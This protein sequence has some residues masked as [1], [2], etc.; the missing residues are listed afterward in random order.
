MSAAHL[1]VQMAVQARIWN[2]Q[3]CLRAQTTCQSWCPGHTRVDSMSESV[4]LVLTSMGMHVPVCSQRVRTGTCPHAKVLGTL[5]WP[6]PSAHICDL[7]MAVG[8]IGIMSLQLTAT[9][10]RAAG[11]SGTAG[12]AAGV[13][14]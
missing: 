2:A 13:H 9:G 1:G 4:V 14:E 7:A 11:C 12:G 8:I 3:R 5:S 10:G 6:L